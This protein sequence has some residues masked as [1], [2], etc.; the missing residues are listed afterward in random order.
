[1]LS[2]DTLGDNSYSASYL[3]FPVNILYYATESDA[4]NNTSTGLEGWSSDGSYLAGQGSGAGSG[5][6]WAIVGGGTVTYGTTLSP[7]GVTYSLYPYVA[8]PCFAKGTHIRCITLEGEK[9]SQP[10]ETL[11]PGQCVETYLHGMQPI[12]AIGRHVIHAPRNQLETLFTLY[13]GSSSR[14]CCLERP[15]TLTGGHSVLV[16]SLTLEQETQTKILLGKTYQ[17]DG[18]QRLMTC[19][20]P[21]AQAAAQ[22]QD[23]TVYHLSISHE[24]RYIN[25]GIYAEG[26]LVE[27]CS[28]R[29]L[30]SHMELCMSEK[31]DIL[32]SN[33]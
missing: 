25:F 6:Q 12:A 11:I 8:A 13:P 16:P 5:F 1:V 7:S 2:T 31:N 27:S 3:L 33:Q 28:Q 24:N 26:L 23:V 14:C 20:I 17:T 19:L 32:S 18:L 10:I 30:E 9:G 21:E 15:L 29:W 4:I 22:E